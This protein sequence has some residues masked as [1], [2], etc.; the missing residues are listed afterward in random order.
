[1]KRRAF[2]KN[3]AMISAGIS[4]YPFL[5]L[6]PEGDKV[7]GKGDVIAPGLGS[8]AKVLVL[9]GPPQRRGQIYGESLK[10]KIEEILFQW[11]EL[12]HSSRKVHPDQYIKKFV[13]ETDFLSAIKKWTPHLIEEVQGIGEGADIDFPTIFAF[14][15]MDEEWLYGAKAALNRKIEAPPRCSG[16]G[17]FGQADSPAIQG[18]N[19][20]LPKFSDSFQVVLH[21]KH[22]ES[23]LES[24]VFTF[25]GLIVL[26]GMNNRPLGVCCNTLSELN[27]STDGLPV[28]FVLR[29]V[30]EQSGLEEAVAFIQTVK[31]A[32]G[33]NYIIGGKEK[34][35]DFECS[36]NQKAQFVP[37]K[38][39]TR[40]YHT[41]HSLANNDK[42]IS[43]KQELSNSETR[44][45][46]LEKR[47]KDS[48]KNL[49]V[50]KI[51]T[52]LGSHDHPLHPICKHKAEEKPGLTVGCSIMVLSSSP[53]FHFA[54]GPPCMT[55]FKTYRF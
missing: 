11:K 39:A 3:G 2:L 17:A 21:I 28:A 46:S 25:A 14:Q 6:T 18:Q 47:L 13:E 31:H 5:S 53:E 49:T 22:P 24:F 54:P 20:D 15:L 37:T 43:K 19:M 29:G 40:V 44:F 10:N 42:D 7:L 12:L 23:S 35:V 4:A 51:K 52:I 9:E 16:L 38:D 41:N 50:E 30:L 34:V 8:E 45:R 1:M 26:N 48:P 32:S 36:A 55:E 33:Q 27:H